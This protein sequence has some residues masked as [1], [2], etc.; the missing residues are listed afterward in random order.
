MSFAFDQGGQFLRYDPESAAVARIIPGGTTVQIASIK[1]EPYLTEDDFL[2][3]GLEVVICIYMCLCINVRTYMRAHRQ[4]KS[5][6]IY[7]YIVSFGLKFIQE[8]R[9]I[10]SRVCPCLHTIWLGRTPHESSLETFVFRPPGKIHIRFIGLCLV[11]HGGSKSI[12][13]CPSLTLR[14]EID[15]FECCYTYIN[16]A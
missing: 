4:K 8:D 13:I 14:Q 11:K 12:S 16:M 2:R 7:I 1:M 9:G 3:L 5:I 10:S 15:G 6:Y